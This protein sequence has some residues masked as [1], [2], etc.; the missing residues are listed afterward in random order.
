MKSVKWRFENRCA[1]QQDNVFQVNMQTGLW[2]RPRQHICGGSILNNQWIVTAAHCFSG[3]E[4]S[5]DYTIVAGAHN[6]L[7]RETTIQDRGISRIIAH[8]G[9]N[10]ENL[11][12]CLMNQVSKE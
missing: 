7:G 3:G 1:T 11:M 9:W 2:Q 8:P 4:N 10:A 12:V 6:A 5:S